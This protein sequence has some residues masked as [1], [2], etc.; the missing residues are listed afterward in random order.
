M[1]SLELRNSHRPGHKSL[2]RRYHDLSGTDYVHVASLPAASAEAFG[3]GGALV[4]YLRKNP[5]A[6][7]APWELRVLHGGVEL[8]GCF[9]GDDAKALLFEERDDRVILAG[10]ELSL[11][12]RALQ[13]ARAALARFEAEAD[14]TRRRIGDIERE[15]AEAEASAPESAADGD[16]EVARDDGNSFSADR[17]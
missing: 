8:P 14:A 6:E 16:V 7:A 12:R 4:V 2:V 3:S 10:G 1:S 11:K 9:V 17:L 5:G 13:L 15:I